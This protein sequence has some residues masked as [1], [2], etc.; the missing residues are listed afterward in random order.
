M[1]NLDH[2]HGKYSVPGNFYGFKLWVKPFMQEMMI[3]N[4][5]LLHYIQHFNKIVTST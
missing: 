5:L 1:S 2:L 4:F 3:Q